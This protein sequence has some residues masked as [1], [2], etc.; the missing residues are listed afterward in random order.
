MNIVQRARLLHQLFPEEITGYMELVEELNTHILAQMTVLP[1]KQDKF[2]DLSFEEWIAIIKDID[3]RIKRYGIR[4]IRRSRL[5]ADQLF[6]GYNALHMIRCL[7]I[8][9]T[10]K[11]PSN[12][13]FS[14]AATLLLL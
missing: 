13:K 3:L 14:Q 7:D 12:L 11:K 5:F 8:Y 10:I 4:L 2:L 9:C 6:D 1:D